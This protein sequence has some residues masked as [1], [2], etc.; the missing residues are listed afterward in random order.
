MKKILVMFFVFKDLVINAQR[1]GGGAHAHWDATHAFDDSEK[2]GGSG[3][4]GFFIK[5]IIFI[6]VIYIWSKNSKDK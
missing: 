3:F 4:L 5:I 6:I 2:G 1:Y